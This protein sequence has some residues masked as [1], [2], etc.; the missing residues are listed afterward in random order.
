MYE[1]FVWVPSKGWKLLRKCKEKA[2]A[3]ALAREWEPLE[4]MVRSPSGTRRYAG[5]LHLPSHNV[6]YVDTLDE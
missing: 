1:I 2:K 3:I 6:K 4:V 5:I